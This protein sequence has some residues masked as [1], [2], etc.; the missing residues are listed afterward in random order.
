MLV[1]P[2]AHQCLSRVAGDL[3]IDAHQFQPTRPSGE[4]GN[5]EAGHRVALDSRVRAIRFGR[6]TL[7]KHS[8]ELLADGAPV[9]L[10]NR[11]TDILLVLIERYGRLVTAAL[12]MA[13]RL[14]TLTGSGGNGKT[15]LAIELGRQ[16]LPQFDG[17]VWVVELGPL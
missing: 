5:Q 2:I 15:R 8:R 16:L 7:I 1:E 11:A 13:N 17:G 10:G 12:V 9:I 3:P 14:V 6:F 4:Y